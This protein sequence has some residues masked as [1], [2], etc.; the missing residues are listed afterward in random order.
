M[1][2]GLGDRDAAPN[3]EYCDFL[4]ICTHAK[5]LCCTE[6]GKFQNAVLAPAEKPCA[7]PN[8]MPTHIL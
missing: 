7:F 2:T 8:T 1:P 6:I 4:G 5:N 3:S